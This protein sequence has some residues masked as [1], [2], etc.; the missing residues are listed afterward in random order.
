[1]RPILD[2]DTVQIEITN[3][4][5]HSCSNCTRLIGHH[6]KPYFMPLEQVKE[7]IDSM[8]GYPK[9]TGIMGGEPLLHPQFKEICEYARSKILIGQ[10]GLWTCLPEGLEHYRDDIVATFQHIFINDHTKNDIYHTP[11]LVAAK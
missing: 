7:A 9:M 4:C 1:M 5:I 3:N 8:V 11:V 2:M 6:K 10:L